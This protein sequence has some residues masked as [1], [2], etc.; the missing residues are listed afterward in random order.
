M[1]YTCRKLVRQTF[2]FYKANLLLNGQPVE[3]LPEYVPYPRLKRAI[4]LKTG[5]RIK[6]CQDLTFENYGDERHAH[7]EGEA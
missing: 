6:N 5:I 3:G 2:S 1:R 7:F 4:R